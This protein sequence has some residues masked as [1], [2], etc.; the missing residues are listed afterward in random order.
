MNLKKLTLGQTMGR[1]TEDLLSGD[2]ITR[3]ESVMVRHAQRWLLVVVVIYVCL[4]LYVVVTQSAALDPSEAVSCACSIA[5]PH[6][7]ES[8][9]AV[10]LRSCLGLPVST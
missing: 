9:D 6:G 3:I 4:L 8:V 7:S 5:V 2:S 10:C 1:K